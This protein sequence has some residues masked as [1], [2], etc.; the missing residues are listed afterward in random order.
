MTNHGS[1]VYM[2]NNYMP[3]MN[4]TMEMQAIYNAAFNYPQN[5][6]IYSE[7]ESNYYNSTQQNIP[8]PANVPKTYQLKEMQ[9]NTRITKYLEKFQHVP[10]SF[11]IVPRGDHS[12]YDSGTY[13]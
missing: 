4:N 5:Q 1:Y 11:D 12:E 8:Q 13:Q 3:S 9:T 7:N 2:P 10:K 6:Q